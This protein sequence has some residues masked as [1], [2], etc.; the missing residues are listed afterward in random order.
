VLDSKLAAFQEAIADCRQTICIQLLQRY[1]VI[2]PNILVDEIE[3]SG[4]A[5]TCQSGEAVF[6]E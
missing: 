4:T 3:R 1:P 6:S 5:S 2:Y